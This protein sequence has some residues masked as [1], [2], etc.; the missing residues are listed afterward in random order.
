MSS[1]IGTLEI[2]KNLSLIEE[3]AAKLMFL[4]QKPSLNEEEKLQLFY[5]DNG[6]K[7]AYGFQL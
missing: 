5:Y 7:L 4:K 1:L 6:I 2:P 3:E